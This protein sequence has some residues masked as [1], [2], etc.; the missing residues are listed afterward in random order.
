MAKEKLVVTGLP[1]IELY[2]YTIYL[3]ALLANFIIQLV[4]ES[5]SIN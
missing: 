5:S 3:G 4:L 2:L 1:K